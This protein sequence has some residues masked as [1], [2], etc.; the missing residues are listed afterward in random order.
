M[1]NQ[2]IKDCFIIKAVWNTPLSS[3]QKINDINMICKR[4]LEF[5]I[6]NF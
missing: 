4:K 2:I 5:K 3:D 1:Q 6:P